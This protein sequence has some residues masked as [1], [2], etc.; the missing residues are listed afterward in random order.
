VVDEPGLLELMK[1]SGCTYLLLGFESVNSASLRRVGKSFDQA[2][3]YRAVVE[4]L[5][6]FGIIIQGCFIFGFDEDEPSVFAST[7]EWINQVRVDIP[8]FALY[9]PYP[10]TRLFRRLQ[11]EGRLLHT[12]WKYY[13]TQHVVIRP[14]GM[15]PAQLESGFQWTWRECFRLLP[16]LRRSLSSGWNMPITFLGNL[17]YRLYIRRLSADQDRFPAGLQE[18][19]RATA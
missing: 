4:R 1:R 17:A 13:D 18:E 12:N 7:L 16:S 14:L 8:R 2:D 15:S 3:R 10:R 6:E 9:T 11:R 5:H 19:Q